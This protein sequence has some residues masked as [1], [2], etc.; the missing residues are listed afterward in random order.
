MGIPRRWN[1]LLAVDR[2]RRH[3][4]HFRVVDALYIR[5][6]K[7]VVT[8]YKVISYLEPR[9]QAQPPRTGS[10]DAKKTPEKK[11][12]APPKAADKP[13]AP[14]PAKPAPSTTPQAPTPVPEPTPQS[15]DEMET[16]FKALPDAIKDLLLGGRP[17]KPDDLPQLLRIAKKLAQLQPEDLAVYKLLA[18]QLAADLDSFERSVDFFIKFKEQIKAQA[19]AEKKEGGCG[20]GADA[21]REAR[22]NLGEV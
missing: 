9:G 7:G 19:D 6:E 16:A 17:L 20:Q 3:I 1:L 5:N 15:R 18:K 10:D 8:G 21:R 13:K 2:I 4:R 14:K 11:P 22:E 12:K